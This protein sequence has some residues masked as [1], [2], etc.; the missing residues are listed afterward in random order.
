MNKRL[1]VLLFDLLAVALLS[2]LLRAKL[3]VDF[4]AINYLETQGYTSV[5]ILQVLPEGRGC[6]NDEYRFIFDAISPETQKRESG[7]VCGDLG[8]WHE[9]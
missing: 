1:P 4:S 7:K 5:R 8:S 3:S 6:P 2:L 9:E